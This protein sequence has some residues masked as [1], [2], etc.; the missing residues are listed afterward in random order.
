M[1]ELLLFLIRYR[2]T[3]G[4][5]CH[6]FWGIC[7]KHTAIGSVRVDL[8]TY[9]C[10]KGNT[11]RRYICSVLLNSVILSPYTA[12]FVYSLIS[13]EYEHL[14]GKNCTHHDIF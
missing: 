3:L 2:D 10:S 7:W 1:I 11:K 4:V 5:C 9:V 8:H 12:W 14:L 6:C 13:N